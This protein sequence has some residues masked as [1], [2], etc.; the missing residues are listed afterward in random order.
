M[1]RVHGECAVALHF[2]KQKIDTQGKPHAPAYSYIGL[3]KPSCASCKAFLATFRDH[4]TMLYPRVS[5]GKL[6]LPWKYPAKELDKAGVPDALKK[7]ILDMFINRVS[8]EFVRRAGHFDEEEV[9]T[10]KAKTKGKKRLERAEMRRRV[11]RRLFN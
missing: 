8:L 3:S 9:A 5:D 4:A 6:R 1:V 11:R 7:D 10:R 2:L